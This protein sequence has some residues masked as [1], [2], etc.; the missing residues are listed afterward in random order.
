MERFVTNGQ[1]TFDRVQG[2]INPVG[3]S[4]I[5]STA[6]VVSAPYRPVPRAHR[7]WGPILFTLAMGGGIL[8]LGLEA[9]NHS[10]SNNTIASAANVQIPKQHT[11]HSYHLQQTA[12]IQHAGAAYAPL[13]AGYS[14]TTVVIHQQP[15]AGFIANPIRHFTRPTY[16]YHQRR[17]IVRPPVIYHR[18]V[19]VFAPNPPRQVIRR[20]YVRYANPQPARVIYNAPRVVYYSAPPPMRMPMGCS[21]R[22]SG[23][24]R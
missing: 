2:T 16:Q 24:R 15:Y 1:F 6:P 9:L 23:G 7:N 19:R 3:S 5:H 11:T 12:P 13:A 4:P 8:L 22:C 20:V 17:T 18:Y 21:F 10:G 14:Q